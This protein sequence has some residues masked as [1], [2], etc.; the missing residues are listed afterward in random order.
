MNHLI[1]VLY[2]IVRLFKYLS[3]NDSQRIRHIIIKWEIEVD[4]VAD[5]VINTILIT[6]QQLYKLY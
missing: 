1:H 3:I 2:V 6:K 5:V 4:Y